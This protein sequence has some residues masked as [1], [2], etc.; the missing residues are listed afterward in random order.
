MTHDEGTKRLLRDLKDLLEK[1]SDPLRRHR[2]EQLI[3]NAEELDY[4]DFRSTQWAMP[5]ASLM[6]AAA[7]FQPIVNGVLSGDY[8][9]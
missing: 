5:K 1:E 3:K 9:N 4:H 8:D 7:T 2:L 6:E